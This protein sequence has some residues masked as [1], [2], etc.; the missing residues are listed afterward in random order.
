MNELVHS[1]RLALMVW[2][3]VVLIGLAV[4]SAVRWW[5]EH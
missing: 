5:H 2:S 3:G 1:F 4:V